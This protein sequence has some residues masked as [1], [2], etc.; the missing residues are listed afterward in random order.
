MPNINAILTF[1]TLHLL[2]LGLPSMIA[3]QLD[4]L[5]S[6]YVSNYVRIPNS[7]LS[8]HRILRLCLYLLVRYVSTVP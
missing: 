4:Y 5:S 8:I 3:I 1:V 7:A 2:Q 6:I